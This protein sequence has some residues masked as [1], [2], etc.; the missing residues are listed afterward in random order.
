MIDP[1]LKKDQTQEDDD[2]CDLDPTKTC[3]NCMK[4]IMD[5]DYSAITIS[6]IMLQDED[7]DQTE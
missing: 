5:S 1:K 4:C 2:T 3:D 6:G 7:E